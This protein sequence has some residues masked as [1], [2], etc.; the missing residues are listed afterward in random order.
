MAAQRGGKKSARVELATLLPPHPSNTPTARYFR[1]LREERGIPPVD[2]AI[3][4]V[5][6]T[7]SMAREVVALLPAAPVVLD[8]A[9]VEV[10]GPTFVDELLTLRPD[11]TAENLN[12]DAAI[13]WE[14]AAERHR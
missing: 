6:A 4:R 11:I 13:S 12:E 14:L 3:H 9:R 8:C 5:F 10:T 7:R 2:P 1:R